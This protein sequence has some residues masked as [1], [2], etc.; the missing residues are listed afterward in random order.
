MTVAPGEVIWEGTD[1]LQVGAI[2]VEAPL[3]PWPQPQMPTEMPFEP[4]APE[5]RLS[6]EREARSLALSALWIASEN[7]PVW[8]PPGAGHLAASPAVALDRLERAGL[9]VHPWSL[10]PAPVEGEAAGRVVFDG[11]GRDRWH[12]PA[13]PAP[14]EPALVFEAVRGE[15]LDILVVGGRLAGAR[16]PRPGDIP[17]EAAELAE[18]AADLLNLPIVAVS[19]V[20]VPGTPEVLLAE[21]GPDLAQW[22]THLDGRLA[23]LL[24]ERLETAALGAQ[25]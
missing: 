7:R 4:P 16:G 5:A 2:L 11:A 10:E 20:A 6:P 3:F 8:N 12:H 25:S 1:L 18:C 21:A 14:G 9:R 19:I 24:I 23:P 13:R 15:V 22:D 17:A